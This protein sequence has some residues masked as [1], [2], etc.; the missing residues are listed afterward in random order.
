V[1]TDYISEAVG[2]DLREKKERS[3]ENL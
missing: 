2:G 1:A 3:F